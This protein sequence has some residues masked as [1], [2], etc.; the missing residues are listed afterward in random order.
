MGP[1]TLR[2]EGIQKSRE[3]FQFLK[4]FQKT[5]KKIIKLKCNFFK[6]FKI[7][8][9]F[10]PNFQNLFR[11]SEFLQVPLRILKSGGKIQISII[12]ASPSS[13]ILT[14]IIGESE[15]WREKFKFAFLPRF[16]QKLQISYIT[17]LILINFADSDTFQ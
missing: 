1:T 10:Y 5:S 15:K 6:I 17:Y 3:F 8:S 12:P 11:L 4:D 13:P 14:K 2:V 16:S 7:F 9:K